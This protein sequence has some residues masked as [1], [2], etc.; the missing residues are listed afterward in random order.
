[1]AMVM[2]ST[3]VGEDAVIAES[4]FGTTR[5]PAAVEMIE[6]WLEKQYG[7]AGHLLSI[8]LSVGAA[9]PILLNDGRKLFIKIWPGAVDTAA[10]TGQL[11]LRGLMLRKGF[12]APAILLEPMPLGP[13]IAALMTYD[14]SGEPTDVR[15]PG[16]R[17]G[18]AR[19]L[20]RFVSSARDFADLPNLPRRDIRY[21]EKLWP[22]PHNALFNFEETTKDA[23]WIE[24]I[25]SN[26]LEILRKASSEI[27]VGHHD[28]S[29]KNM[30]MDEDRLAV[31]YDWDAVFINRETFVLGGAA[32]HF[33][34]T[35]EL[36]VPKNPTPA[37]MSSFVRAYEKERGRSF[38]RREQAEIVASI[39]YVRAYTVRCE[40]ALDTGGKN[41]P[42]STREVLSRSTFELRHLLL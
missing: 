38:S 14:R 20:A 25:A 8:E 17:E 32:A 35:W 23:K 30:R 34:T 28:W 19:W 7:E 11:C 3:W 5:V 1:M 31:L 9:V 27:V 42:G 13:G 15:I 36:P 40:H 10:L 29:A 37:E 22:K 18:M 12:P 26:A 4:V 16:V 21:S 33:P 24:D 41:W 2:A 6:N 39:N